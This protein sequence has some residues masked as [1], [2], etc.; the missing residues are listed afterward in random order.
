MRRLLC[1]YC[2]TASPLPETC[3]EC[4]GNLLR[5]GFGTE[6]VEAEVAERFPRARVARLDRDAASSSEKLTDILAS[7]ARRELD[8]LV[9][10]QMV[11]KGHDFPGVTL[12][13]V[14][15]ADTA[16]ALPDF[17]AAERTFHLLTQVGGR[18]GRG[19]DPG[20]VLVQTYNPDSEPVRRVLDHDFAGFAE[21]ELERRRAMAYPPFTRLMAV[22]VEGSDPDRTREVAE[23]LGARVA[24]GLA[25]APRGVRLLGP[26]PAPIARIKGK[27]RWQLLLKGPTYAALAPLAARVEEALAEVPAAVKVVIDVDPGAML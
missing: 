7:F 12:V 6:R 19:K 20:R 16:L 2:G 17:R 10:T 13:C 15:M 8:V 9:G 22:R 27:S 11:A 18:A 25:G 26:A 14:V 24:A 1:H 5:L 3:P 21:R 4:R 23:A